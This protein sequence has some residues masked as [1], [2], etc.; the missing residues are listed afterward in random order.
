MPSP[1]QL[2]A[3][4]IFAND[5]RVVHPLNAG[6]MGS[7]YVVQQVSTGAQRALKLMHPELVADPRQRARFEQEAKV[8]ASIKSDHVVKVISAGVDG[9]TGL[10]YIVMELLEGAELGT[11]L[12]Q[13]GILPRGEISL[14]LSQLCHA[15]AAAHAVGIVHRDLKPENVFIAG[16]QRADV[17]FTVKILDFGIAKVVAELKNSATQ[18]VGTPLYMAPEQGDSRAQVSAATDVWSLALMAFQ[19]LTGKCFWLGAAEGGSVEQIMAEVLIY[20]VPLASERAHALGVAHLLPG[21]FDPW[22]KACT[23]RDPRMRFQNGGDAW[24]SLQPI[25]AASL[26]ATA[27]PQTHVP[28]GAYAPVPGQQTGPAQAYA[29]GQRGGYAT[30]PQGYGAQPA[31]AYVTGQGHGG[32]PFGGG[33]AYGSM[34]T[35]AS[36]YPA[37]PPAPIVGGYGAP[38]P[39]GAFTNVP[40]QGFASATA[41]P[42]LGQ[43]VPAPPP[44]APRKKSGP[45]VPI[46]AV[47]G[48][49]TLVGGGIGAYFLFGSKPKPPAEKKDK[50][51]Y[52]DETTAKFHAPVCTAEIGDAQRKHRAT[53]LRLIER[54]GKVV[55]VDNVNAFDRIVDAPDGVAVRTYAYDGKNVSQIIEKNAL[56]VV[57]MKRAV[58]PKGT[59]IKLTDGFDQ[60]ARIDGTLA[61]SLG[62]VLDDK[63]FITETRFF[64]GRGKPTFS[65][66]NVYGY[67]YKLDDKGRVVAATGIDTDGKPMRRSSVFTT[68]EIAFDEHGFVKSHRYLDESGKPVLAASGIGGDERVVDE[69]GNLKSVRYL[70]LDGKPTTGVDGYATIQYGRDDHGLVTRVDLFDPSG[71]PTYDKDGWSSQKR[72]FDDAGNMIEQTFLDAS[73]APTKG[74]KFVTA[75]TKYDARGLPT[76]VAYVLGDGK[77]E[78]VE[79]AYSL[80]KMKYDDRGNLLEK[81]YFDASG[82]P[83]LARPWYATARYTYDDH[84]HEVEANFL[85]TAGKATNVYAGY[86]KVVTKRDSMGNAIE[87]AYFDA[88]GAPIANNE[89]VAKIV[90]G[91]DELGNMTSEANFEEKGNP[92]L[93]KGSWASTK[94]TFDEN[95]N[96]ASNDY[97]GADGNRKKQGDRAGEKL[98]RD[99]YGNVVVAEIVGEN[100]E[101]ASPVAK[102]TYEYDAR[103]D[104]IRA[105]LFD[106]DGK[107]A[108]NALK[109][110]KYEYKYD[111]RGNEIEELD[112]D[113]N[114][115]LV[116][117]GSDAGHQSKFDA[118]GREIE[119]VFLGAD[120]KPV[121]NY[122]GYARWRKKYDP[123]GKPLEETYFDVDDRPTRSDS[124]YATTRWEYDLDGNE[125]HEYLFD[126]E[127]K[128][129]L[130]LRR[131]SGTHNEYDAHGNVV[132]TTQTDEKGALSK[133]FLI[134]ILKYDDRNLLAEEDLFDGDN[135]PAINSKNIHHYAWKRDA[136]GRKTEEA[137]SGTDGLPTLDED[138]VSIRR[139]EYDRRG[140]KTKESYFGKDGLPKADNEGTAFVVF[141]FDS[142][143]KQIR[144]EYHKLDG[145][146]LRETPY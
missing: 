87:T 10:P 145:S 90:R 109:T 32:A 114:G 74:D 26:G 47:G 80:L 135:K 85:D 105:L 56:G 69:F 41:L 66:D 75:K 55:E 13:R 31:Q 131:F 106:K 72:S 70:A 146:I 134:A 132:K 123:H 128:P 39:P 95:G 144:T 63:G 83:V 82:K 15:L 7:V 48:A 64:N 126:A 115:K 19:M 51:T 37:A 9:P 71:R 36:G 43:S 11:M 62:Y 124:N 50:I 91:F 143:D 20:D 102:F 49:L 94:R 117:Y 40:N 1:V 136:H 57:L 73:G 96:R 81:S 29:T 142:A 46:L 111:E 54:E 130:N 120:G 76:E 141:V 88:D 28:S 8:G 116:V 97:F 61:T 33:G 103:N 17:P 113:E 58:D 93:K 45:L 22:F 16:S 14:I 38:P 6:G 139:F 65:S 42:A 23:Q 21:G 129:C 68:D 125:I 127:G 118:W 99:L 79:Q 112:Y 18:S 89:G 34:A 60:P 67:R 121:K 104:R 137:Y 77:P 101:P 5:F 2:G 24:R 53:T 27:L 107:A 35:S 78:I 100:G 4:Q 92:V 12:H 110:A 84:D 138:G 86:S 25:L 44:A 108:P 140:N 122:D 59:S 30:G 98:T 52:C 119:H 3:G 133:F